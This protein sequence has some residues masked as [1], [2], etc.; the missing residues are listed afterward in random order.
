[1]ENSIQCVSRFV[2]YWNVLF[3]KLPYYKILNH[4]HMSTVSLVCI[5][6]FLPF[7]T[8]FQ[9]STL[10]YELNYLLT[11]MGIIG[12]RILFFWEREKENYKYNESRVRSWYIQGVS[13]RYGQ[14]ES[15]PLSLNNKK[16]SFGAISSN[17][18]LKSYEPPKIATEIKFLTLS[19]I[20]QVGK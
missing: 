17:T 2:S 1:M 18:S 20:W 13:M 5:G 9:Y 16:R 8:K 7:S 3:R 12:L 19:Q 14:N 10:Y 15:L 6:L 4:N 11:D